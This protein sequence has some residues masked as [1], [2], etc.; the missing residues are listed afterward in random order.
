M[1]AVDE[2]NEAPWHRHSWSGEL[3]TTDDTA[4]NDFTVEDVARVIAHGTTAKD[5]WDGKCAGIVRLKDGRYVSWE[6]WWGPT[7]S[8]F[9]NDAY[10]GDA[11]IVFSRT[12]KAATLAISES[13][14]ELLT[15][16]TDAEVSQ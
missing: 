2:I 1:I 8:G 3:T 4:T 14:R 6:S 7:G 13:A 16:N 9:C 10:G 5:D 15:W 12:I 11:D